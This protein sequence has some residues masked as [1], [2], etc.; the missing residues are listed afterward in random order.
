MRHARFSVKERWWQDGWISGEDA[1]I[2]LAWIVLL[3]HMSNQP[4]DGGYPPED[5]LFSEAGVPLEKA[6]AMVAKAKEAAAIL[7]TKDGRWI[8]PDARPPRVSRRNSASTPY[9]MVRRALCIVASELGV[10]EPDD[11]SVRRHLAQTSPLRKLC[12]TVGPDA[13][14][15]AFVCAAR[16]WKKP[17]TWGAVADNYAA[18]SVHAAKRTGAAMD[19]TPFRRW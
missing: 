10:P 12:E 2:K 14:A 16:T 6:A 11:A 15:A 18:L 19:G 4:R 1:E 8:V 13:A 9:P 17:P 7:T 5:S 3:E